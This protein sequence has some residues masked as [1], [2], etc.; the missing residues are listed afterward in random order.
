MPILIRNLSKTFDGK[1]VL[2]AFFHDFP[3]RSVT[4][5]VGP[6]GCGKTTLLHLIMG[7]QA[8]DGGEITGLSGRT[9]AAVFQED[10]LFEHCS[11]TANLRAVLS[12]RNALAE[13]PGA[14]AA[15]GLADAAFQPVRT[16]SGGMKRRVAILRAILADADVLLMDE[17]FR[18]LDTDTRD[19]VIRWMQP[20][21]NGRMV[22]MVTHDPSEAQLLGGRI[23]SLNA[24]GTE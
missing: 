14:L 18:G 16:L 21:L 15:V 22:I 3:D 12:N 4:C 8:P 7:L 2:S 11:P 17:P 24:K 1:A 19:T 23:L 9:I 6:S 5:I 10:R 20:R 13:I